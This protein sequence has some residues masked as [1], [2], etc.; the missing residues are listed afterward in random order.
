[1]ADPLAADASSRTARSR[2]WLRWLAFVAAASLLAA[3]VAVA[4]GQRE[5]TGRVLEAVGHPSGVVVAALLGSVAANI[6][7]SGFMFSL[8]ISR[9]GKVGVVEMQ[10]VI[11]AATLANFVPLRPGLW[12]R[13]AYHQAI[14][15]IPAIDSAK[16]VGQAVVLSVLVA[17]YLAA[18]VLVFSRLAFPLWPA[19][20]L[21][22]PVLAVGGLWRPGRVWLWAGLMRYL[23]VLVWAAR[24]H[25][26]FALID[27]PVGAEAVLA[28]AC[29]SV[30]TMLVPFVGNGL[31][32]REWAIG[33][34]ALWLTPYVLE[35][36]LTAELVNRAAE[37]IVV[38]ALGSAS[39]VW[40]MKR[41]TKA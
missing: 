22:V 11:A 17:A 12:G 14:H 40:L 10:A 27:A 18:A 9:Y 3:A 32:L 35:L 30:M 15:R 26:A 4:W 20:L 24:Y 5:V 29:V 2:V 6:I 13:I 7:L 33:V 23:D 34:A 39:M 31:G 38:V 41:G 25:A 19:V 1:M 8:L 28:F 36:G 21:P 37:L 16:T